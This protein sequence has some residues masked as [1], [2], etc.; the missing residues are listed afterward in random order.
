MKIENPKHRL[1]RAKEDLRTSDYDVRLMFREYIRYL[2]I[3]IIN[4][5][6]FWLFYELF[7]WIDLTA[8]PATVAWAI[9]YIIG[10]FEAHFLHRKITFKSKANYSESLF[11]AFVVYGVIGVVS[12]ISEHI[13]VYVFDLN[14]RVAWAVNMSMFGFM[15]FLG[16][17]L[18]AFPPELDSDQQTGPSH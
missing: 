5:I 16:L 14:H 9:A 8:Y 7:Y 2:G 18:L 6:F 15:M 3:A 1:I 10:S 13:L 4:G 11:W 12:T 17:R